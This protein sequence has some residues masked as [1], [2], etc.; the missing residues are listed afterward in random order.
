MFVFVQVMYYAYEV[1]NVAVHTTTYAHN[2]I[3]SKTL[4]V[5]TT[6]L[7]TVVNWCC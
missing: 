3:C 5:C 6:L 1:G 2:T 7:F 4:I